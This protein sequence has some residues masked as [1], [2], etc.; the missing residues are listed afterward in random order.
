L[1]TPHPLKVKFSSERP[2]YPMRLTALANSE[3][4]LLLFVGSAKRF[5]RPKLNLR[6]ADRIKVTRYK[7]PENCNIE[8]TFFN[9][10]IY[11]Y[12]E[13]ADIM[14]GEEWLT[15]FKTR[16]KP[17][18]M[19]EDIILIESKDAASYQDIFYSR[20]G[21]RAKSLSIILWIFTCA[22]PVIGIIF[23]RKRKAGALAA[24]ILIC[25]GYIM[26]KIYISR[27]PVK[28]NL[29][30]SLGDSRGKRTYQSLLSRTLSTVNPGDYQS[31]GEYRSAV[32]DVLEKSHANLFTGLPI[33]EEHS[34]GNIGF[35]KNKDG[36]LNVIWYDVSCSS[37]TI[38]YP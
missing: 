13:L 32:I 14:E 29:V 4:E 26:G 7:E 11:D 30:T 15:C 10:N 6:F 20:S 31:E 16:L 19:N 2:I 5:E 33:Q 24:L 9:R 27:L 28:E 37:Y 22:F 21:A 1:M 17:E 23:R 35:R 18:D 25:L 8:A 36:G 12:K 3:T 34:P 38:K